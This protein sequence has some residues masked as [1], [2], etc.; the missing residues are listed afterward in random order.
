[1]KIIFLDIDGVLVHGKTNGDNYDHEI[2]Y[3][4]FNTTS[5]FFINQ[6]IKLSGA[7]IVITST[8][9]LKGIDY[10][11]AVWK[12]EEMNGEIIGITPRL[13]YETTP[14]ENG[15]RFKLL[16]PRGLEIKDYLNKMKKE[17]VDVEK[18]IIIDD[19]VD[20]LYT[21]R[22]KF[23]KTNTQIGFNFELYKNTLCEILDENELDEIIKSYRESLNSEN[24]QDLIDNV[25]RNSWLETRDVYM[26][27][28][29]KNIDSIDFYKKLIELYEFKYIPINTL[30]KIIS[31]KRDDLLVFFL[32]SLPNAIEET[33]QHLG[34]KEK[35]HIDILKKKLDLTASS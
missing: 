13:F 31:E 27:L 9:R 23:I 2:G 6:L 14:N 12:A 32:V 28:N 10:L 16:V 17:G 18:Y 33:S 11:Q 30:K 35:E 26:I 3:R 24:I 29:N 34:E 7:K 25:N 4:K 1:M 20:M 15:E 21:Q 22:D 8:W 5:K 19:D